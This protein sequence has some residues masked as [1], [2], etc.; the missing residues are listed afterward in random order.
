M[1]AYEACRGATSKRDSPWYVVPEDD[2]PNARLIV[3]QIILDTFEDLGMSYPKI[4][5]DR[6][7]ELLV[8]R[9]ELTT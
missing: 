9:G 4:S 8:I 3:S 5:A 6:E 7:R 1:K 2:K